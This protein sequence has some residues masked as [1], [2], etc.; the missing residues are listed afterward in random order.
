MSST[1]ATEA[2]TTQ[3]EIPLEHPPEVSVVQTESLAPVAPLSAPLPSSVPPE[4]M[5]QSI[6]VMILTSSRPVPSLKLA[7]A[8]GLI[9]PDAP[10]APEAA[11]QAETST[12]PPAQPEAAAADATPPADGDM[13]PS[14]ATLPP[15]P[16]IRTRRKSKGPKKADPEVLIAQSVARLNDTYAATNRQFRIELVAGGYRLLTLP[17]HHALLARFHGLAAQTRL[18]KPAVET[19]AIIA[20]KQPVT[21]AQLEAIR[22]VACGE[23]LRSLLDRRLINIVGRAEE[24]GRPMLYGTTRGFLE[25]FG[26]ASLK[27]LPAPSDLSLTPA[28][29]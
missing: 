20:Y 25:L 14:S 9:E 7:V 26:L 5:D 17:Q 1:D 8:L 12:Q 2:N 21:R 16:A 4:V 22:G 19:L 29:L 24:L 13:I 3:L 15:A 6:E 27:D 28:K 10:V 18:S 23:V 11:V